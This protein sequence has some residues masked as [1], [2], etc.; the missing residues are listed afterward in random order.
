MSY[1]TIAAITL[2]AC[3]IA[4]IANV[5]AA[6]VL[7]EAADDDD[8]PDFGV[9]SH[10]WPDDGGEAYEPEEGACYKSGYG[11][12]HIEH[13]WRFVDERNAFICLD[14]GAWDYADDD[15]PDDTA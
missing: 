6:S 12:L 8:A 14:C 9:G 2:I 11:E 13:R 1:R 10:R 7:R 15:E 5:I 3:V 4:A